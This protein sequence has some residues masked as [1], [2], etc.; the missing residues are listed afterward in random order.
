MGI[1]YNSEGIQADMRPNA[2]SMLDHRLQRWPTM[3]EPQKCQPV[4]L[5]VFAC[6]VT[7]P[8]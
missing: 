5:L 1:P 8:I 4:Y 6:N 7:P 2:D 3:L